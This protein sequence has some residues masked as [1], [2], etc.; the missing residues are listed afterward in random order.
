MQSL[1]DLAPEPALPVDL[2]TARAVFDAA[3][4]RWVAS[5]RDLID[6]FVDRHFGFRG[7]ARLHRK[8]LGW[9]VFRAPANVALVPPQ[10]ALHAGSVAA[11]RL[12][13]RR[14]GQW[15]ATRRLLLRTDVDREIEW[16]LWTEFLELPYRDGDR[17]SARD[18]LV[19]SMLA[20]PRLSAALAEPLAE[21]ARHAGDPDIRRRIEE[22]VSAYTGARAAAADITAALVNLGAGYL[23]TQQI[24]PS[25]WTLGPVLA[26]AIAQKAAIAGF[27]LGSSLGS[28]WYGLFPVAVG[29]LAIASSTIGLATVGAMVAAFAGLVADPAQRALGLHRRRL[30][31]M[32]R[33]IETNLRGRGPAVFAPRDLYVARL[34]DIVDLV[35][36]A[37]RVVRGG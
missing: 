19:E 20:D 8:A 6:P 24:T 12:G 11:R 21:I 32:L 27:P 33:T 1:P 2:S 22:T 36:A 4:D 13:A 31:R 18:S 14:A 7:T 3:I 5:R 34:I 9:D 35:R 26:T 37:H 25:A 10:L 16:L 30:D 28:A 17:V 29:P 15:M 23:A